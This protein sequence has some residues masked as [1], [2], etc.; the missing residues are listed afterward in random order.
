MPINS[1]D[2]FTQYKKNSD[3]KEQFIKNWNDCF[4]GKIS[5]EECYRKNTEDCEKS[6]KPSN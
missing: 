6:L 4:S 1:N 2:I 5:I 3:F